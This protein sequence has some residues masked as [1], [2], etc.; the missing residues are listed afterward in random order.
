MRLLIIN[1]TLSSPILMYLR[2][3]TS[4]PVP[5]DIRLPIHRYQISITKPPLINP[6]IGINSQP[7]PIRHPL[8]IDLPIIV[9]AS[10]NPTNFDALD[11][12]ILGVHGERDQALQEESDAM[13]AKTEAGIFRQQSVS[14]VHDVMLCLM[15]CCGSLPTLGCSAGAPCAKPICWLWHCAPQQLIVNLRGLQI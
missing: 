7:N 11:G 14:N 13:M 15:T 2:L 1:I 10:N 6:P 4:N 8:H 9:A 5:K 3:L 12:V